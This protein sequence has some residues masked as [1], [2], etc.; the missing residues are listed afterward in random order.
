MISPEL[1]RRYALFGGLPHD[2]FEAIAQ[3]SDE[4]TLE[5]DTYLFEQSTPAEE[6]ILVLTGTVDL[7]MD[8]DETGDERK[9]IET[10]VAGEF[11]GWS[12]I[13]EPHIYTLSAVTTEDS[14][15]IVI[16]AAKFR[17]LL[18]ANHEWGYLVM[19]R[20]A[21]MIGMRLTNMRMRLMS[22]SP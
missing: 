8:M 11:V 16:D 17:E 4:L 14:Q 12:A 9:E 20:F 15:L 19:Q 10:V 13:V 3:F 7:L 22:F 1:L 5:A 21:K 18:E 6:L 2:A